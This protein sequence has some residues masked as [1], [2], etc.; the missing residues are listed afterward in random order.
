MLEPDPRGRL[1]D[2]LWEVVAK[3]LQSA[4]QMDGGGV[5]E[6]GPGTPARLQVR[7]N[8][9][10]YTATPW[11]GPGLRATRSCCWPAVATLLTSLS[12][13]AFTIT[14]RW[15]QL[16]FDIC[17]MVGLFELSRGPGLA[18]PAGVW[19]ELLGCV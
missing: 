7:W 16:A 1:I 13:A 17:F 12:R 2:L 3:R 19:P 9:A 18:P 10:M 14:P 5:L 6:A 11:A 15:L 8:T 4:Q